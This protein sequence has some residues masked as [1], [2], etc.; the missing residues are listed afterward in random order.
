M[1][2]F[3]FSAITALLLIVNDLTINIVNPI[4]I[5]IM[6]G[7]TGIVFLIMLIANSH[8]DKNRKKN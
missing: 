6:S 3:T 5:R 4:V 1:L 8:N 7:I 2:F